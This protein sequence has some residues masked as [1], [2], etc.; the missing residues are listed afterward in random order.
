MAHIRLKKG[1]FSVIIVLLIIALLLFA[2]QP[3]LTDNAALNL[4]PNHVAESQ[5][6]THYRYSGS[7]LSVA[8]HFVC[9]HSEL[10]DMYSRLMQEFMVILALFLF[11]LNVYKCVK[12]F[13]NS[14]DLTINKSLQ[15]SIIAYSLGGNA[16]PLS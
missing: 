3:L 10:H 13:F 15:E 14:L 4:N 8:L 1:Y 2:L 7:P 9:D 6:N 11:I 16:P 5:P 12:A